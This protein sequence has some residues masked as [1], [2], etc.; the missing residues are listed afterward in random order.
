MTEPI[1]A[2]FDLDGTITTRDTFLPFLRALDAPRVAVGL[3]RASP[4]IA[5]SVLKRTYR[6]RAKETLVGSTLGGR[7]VAEVHEAAERFA[8]ELI[9]QG[10][11]SEVVGRI[12]HHHSE[13]HR[14]A[15]AS[16]S[17]EVIVEAIA[18]RLGIGEVI[19]TRLEV[20]RGF[21]TGRYADSNVRADEKLRRVI[22]AFGRA[23]DHAYGNLPDDEP[24][25]A[26]SAN[27]FVIQ[28]GHLARYA[29]RSS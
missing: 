9:P 15:I 26:A 27:G 1:V 19:A 24:L 17:P 11:V 2:V 18:K 20:S 4:W 13:G 28:N 7:S 5:M 14:T 6:D 23:P 10:L 16:A 25:L 29:P 8:D 3:V 21:Y 22:E 12:E